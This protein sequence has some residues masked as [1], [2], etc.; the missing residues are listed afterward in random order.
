MTGTIIKTSSV[1]AAVGGLAVCLLTS[2]PRS[3]EGARAVVRDVAAGQFFVDCWIGMKFGEQPGQVIRGSI[4]E[5]P[6]IRAGQPTGARVPQEA[7]EEDEDV[8]ET[9]ASGVGR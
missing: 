3:E 4:C 1:V 2:Q 6:L 8:V 5:R 9:G 7:L